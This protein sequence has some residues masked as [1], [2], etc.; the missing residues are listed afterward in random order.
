[1]RTIAAIVVIAVLG[2][3]AWGFISS[4]TP[5]TPAPTIAVVAST[6]PATVEEVATPVVVAPT[7]APA[8]NTAVVLEP[9]DGPA[10]TEWFQ[11]SAQIAPAE[12]PFVWQWL[13]IQA[14]LSEW[15]KCPYPDKGFCRFAGRPGMWVVVDSSAVR[16]GTKGYDGPSVTII[17]IAADQPQLDIYVHDG[18]VYTFPS[19]VSKADVLEFA[20]ALALNTG[21][22]NR[23]TIAL[24]KAFGK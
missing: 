4:A 7:Q 9:G 17:R 20:K 22:S 16:V 3:F 19:T 2:W 24:I 23:A 11:A 10:V 15:V 14:K 1:M 5:S 21:S 13:P 6:T 8:V 18:Q 12:K